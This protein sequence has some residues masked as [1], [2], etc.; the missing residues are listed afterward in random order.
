MPV[1]VQVLAY[2][3][4]LQY[5]Q[6]VLMAVPLNIQLGTQY[7]GGPRDEPRE[8]TGIPGRLKRAMD[9]HFEGLILFTIAVVVVA[10]GDAGSSLTANCAWAYLGARILY[11]PAY[12]SGVPLLRS[13]IWFVGFA[14]TFVMLLGALL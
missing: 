8:A 5:L 13:A 9:N 14:A 11:V 6:F 7:T 1:E 10:L 12:A 2:A 3:A 4:L